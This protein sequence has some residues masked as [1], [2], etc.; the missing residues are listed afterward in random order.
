MIKQATVTASTE[1]RYDVTT[2]DLPLS[3]PT[4]NMRLWDSHPRVYLPIEKT[5]KETCP[6]CGAQFVLT[7]FDKDK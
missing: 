4:Q 3:C 5:G 2:S 1:Q 6:Y 7:D